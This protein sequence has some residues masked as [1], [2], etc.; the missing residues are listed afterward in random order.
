MTD[1]G[2][3]GLGAAGLAAQLCYPQVGGSFRDLLTVA[4]VLLLAGACVAHAAATRGARWAT[5][6]VVITAGGG[7]LTEF[8]GTTTGVPFGGYAYTTDGALGPELGSVPLLIGPAWTFGAYPA[9][10][11]AQAIVGPGRGAATVLVAAWGLASWDLYLDPQM[12]ADGR[13][14]WTDPGPGLPG[15]VEVPLSNYAGWLLVA[16]VLCAALHRLDRALGTPRR[17][18]DGLPLAL[19]CWTW[20]G[21]ALAHAVFLD[22]PASACYGMVGMGLVGV[23]LLGTLLLSRAPGTGLRAAPGGGDGVRGQHAEPGQHGSGGAGPVE[24]VEVQPR[25]TLGE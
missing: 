21:S 18:T 8:V 5:G 14:V 20:L 12:V 10:C 11:A 1:R 7:L 4:V 23:P 19:F 2:V 17:G 24:G 15:V 25:R 9:W 16:L 22:L 13:W 6:L 3:V